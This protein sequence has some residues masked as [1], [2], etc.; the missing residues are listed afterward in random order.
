MFSRF[1]VTVA[2]TGTAWTFEVM[3]DTVIS[4]RQTELL[5]PV[6]RKATGMK[7]S[8]AIAVKL[9]V[10]LKRSN[11]ILMARSLRAA[12]YRMLTGC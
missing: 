6:P 5:A 2:R 9:T 12:A 4:V 8:P 1:N 7:T 10:R 3:F 11:A